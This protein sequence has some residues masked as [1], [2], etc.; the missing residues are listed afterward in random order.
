MDPRRQRA[1]QLRRARRFLQEGE[2]APPGPHH[3]R[4]RGK[5]AVLDD[6]GRDGLLGA[7]ENPAH[8]QVRLDQATLVDL[9]EGSDIGEHDQMGAAYQ[10]R[11]AGRQ[12][13]R[14]RV[15]RGNEAAN[16]ARV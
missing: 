1:T 2:H 15:G 10:A 12:A 14:R 6:R 3:R 5:P 4:N 9:G 16:S 8:P 13:D 7:A 11:Q